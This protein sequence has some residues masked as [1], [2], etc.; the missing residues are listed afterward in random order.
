MDTVMVAEM[1][2]GCAQWAWAV[3]IK[4]RFQPKAAYAAFEVQR[5]R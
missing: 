5:E 1:S 4:L 2:G 3:A